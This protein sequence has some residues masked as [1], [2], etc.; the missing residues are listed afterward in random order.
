MKIRCLKDFAC[1]KAG[2]VYCVG[3]SHCFCGK[4][5]RKVYEVYLGEE[6]FGAC[7][8]VLDIDLKQYFEE[9]DK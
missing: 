3:N 9:V 4:W 2:S 6:P 1:F 8:E 5:F 7:R